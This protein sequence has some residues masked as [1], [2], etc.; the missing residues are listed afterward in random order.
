MEKIN[1]N[2]FAMNLCC[3]MKIQ[4]CTKEG[5]RLYV[6]LALEVQNL[7]GLSWTY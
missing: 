1:V 3:E 5:S 7:A 4:S 6:I 2:V